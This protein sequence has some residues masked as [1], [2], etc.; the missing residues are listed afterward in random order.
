MSALANNFKKNFAGLLRGLLRKV[1]NGDSADPASPEHRPLQR[2]QSASAPVQHTG[3]PGSLAATGGMQ[4]IPDTFS[5]ARPQGHA[6]GPARAANVNVNASELEM[7]L[8]PILEKLP[9][10]LRAKWM[11]G[12]VDLQQATISVPVKKV[13]PQ[14]ALGTVKI[15]F[16]EL[17]T[18]AP[19]L[20]RTG[21]E[22]D[23]LPI[24]LPLNE[25]LSRLNPTL[26][27]RNPS[28]RVVAAPPMDIAEPFGPGGLGV[29]LGSPTAP[30]TKPATTHFYKKPA[31]PEPIKMASPPGIA[32]QPLPFVPR[33]TTPAAPPPPPPPA[34]AAPPR[35]AAQPLPFTPRAT[36][37]AA[38]PAPTPRVNFNGGA[39]GSPFQAPA[40][41]PPNR[42]PIA[43]TISPIPM[44]KPPAPAAVPAS[45]QRPLVPPVSAPVP[46]APS[47]LAP[48]S[49]LS[50]EWPETLRQEIGQ[51]NLGRCQV[52]LPVHLIEPALRRGRV[53]YSWHH[54]RSWIKP[55][56]PG[57][58]VH[59]AT[60]LELPLRVLAPLFLPATKKPETKS[61]TKAEVPPSSVPNLFFGFPQPQF[62]EM[63]PPVNMPEAV[64]LVKPLDA[65]LND[66]N[67]YV[68]GDGGETP[69]LD[70]TE[71]KRTAAPA[72]DFTSRRAMP[73]E[74][75]QRAM[76]LPGVT[77]AIIALGDG[78]KVAHQ[79]PA[80]LN[81]DTVAA[82]LPQ[83][84]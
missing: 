6:P 78:L 39:H 35:P 54:I 26:I 71:Y 53:I 62:E 76:K 41:P 16:G 49:A 48:L 38:P 58:S 83:L 12:G 13:L 64:P 80:E 55:T 25:V 29:S 24:A 21:E 73:N 27:P 9:A 57:P 66:S 47:I 33:A 52:A 61:Q 31:P 51:L 60:E 15:T 19:T 42:N 14:L 44:P 82:F 79:L 17:R 2:Q 34:P 3:S 22:Y 43:N 37:P 59:D 40:T 74:I 10:D 75:I 20:F 30:A 45:S 84:F 28:Q 11:L 1:D 63:A 18:A 77:G 68:W 69:R 7:P 5:S 32:G 56:P 4:A 72:T 23:S 46:E 70:E 50:E 36:T 8:L 65:K 81:A 67:F